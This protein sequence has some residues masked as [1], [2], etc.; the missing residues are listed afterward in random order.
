MEILNKTLVTGGGGVVASCI[1][2]GVKLDRNN[3]DITNLEQV[4]EVVQ[5]MQPKIILHLAAL[6]D[7]TKCENDPA[8]AY[9]VNSVG[10]YNLAFAAKKVG[11]KMIY[12]STDAVFPHSKSPHVVDDEPS[13]ES[14]YGHS[15]YLGE[16][17]VKGMSEDF[18]I[19]RTSWVFGGGKE[20]DKKFVGKFIDQLEKPEANAVD[21][22]FSSPTYALD[23]VGTLKEFI[24]NNKKGVFHLVNSGIASRYD[25][26]LLIKDILKKETKIN[27]VPA[28]TFGLSLH[29]LS[30]GGLV[31]SVDMRSWGDA[32]TEYLKTEWQNLK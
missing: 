16:L 32:L 4:Q 5:K 10:T 23:L 20:R 25:M 17:A 6:T 19:A 28:S 18:V 27:A 31:S 26:A 29:Q 11:A 1:D 7:L 3:L 22:Q 13:P 21:D 8:L 24:L 12:V 14:V 2:F 15:K 9:L 30:S